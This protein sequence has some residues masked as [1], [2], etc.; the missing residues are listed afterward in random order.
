MFGAIV[1]I[2]WV[3]RRRHVD[4]DQLFLDQVLHLALGL[5]GDEGDGPEAAARVF[6]QHGAAEGLRLVA[7]DRLDDLL[8]RAID[9]ADDRHAG[10][11]VLAEADEDVAEVAGGDPA[12]QRDHDDQ[13]QQPEPG[14]ADLEAEIVAQIG[15]RVPLRRNQGNHMAV[16]EID[17]PVGKRQRD[18]DRRRD[19]HAGE[20]IGP[21]PA[22]DAAAS[23][24][25][26]FGRVMRRV[27]QRVGHGREIV[28]CWAG[29]G[30]VNRLIC[31]RSA[32]LQIQTGHRGKALTA[33]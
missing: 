8:H 25:R 13:D 21:E 6:D 32:G 27:V 20:K 12:D 7:E 3:R 22:P 11:D 30:S 19:E 16:D 15:I 1:L 4:V 29:F 14:Y 33:P 31:D 26:G 5:A 23:F 28:P 2:G 24:R 18:D 9:A 17:Q 10:D